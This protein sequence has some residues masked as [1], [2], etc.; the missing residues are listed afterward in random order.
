MRKIFRFLTFIFIIS[1]L[2]TGCHK[3]TVTLADDTW[4]VVDNNWIL[5][6]YEEAEQENYKNL[7]TQLKGNGDV[8]KSVIEQL[9]EM[10]HGAKT[11]NALGVACLRLR[12]F[13]DAERHLKAALDLSVTKEEKACALTNLSECC[14]Y[15]D[16]RDEVDRY[17]EE[18]YEKDISDP[19]K[20]LIL[21]TNMLKKKYLNS[22]LSYKLVIKTAKKLIKRERKLLGSNQAIFAWILC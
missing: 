13:D 19:M 10:E 15:Q 16:K 12:N 17:K 5:M 7:I 1:I 14:L 2:L 20:R 18:A 3:K 21:D 8:L 4:Y 6:L 22:E 11:E 9:Q